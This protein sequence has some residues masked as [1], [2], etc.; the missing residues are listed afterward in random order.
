MEL[1]GVGVGRSVAVGKVVRMPDPLPEPKDARHSGDAAAEK[2]AAASALTFVAA[3]LRARAEKAD[4]EANEVLTATA[5]MAEDPSIL[6]SVNELIDGGKAAERAVFEAFASFREMLISLGGMMAERATD[7][8]DVSQ[9]VVARLR[10]VEAPGVPQ[11]DE[12]FVLVADDLAPADTALLELDKVLA[13]VTRQGGPTSHTAILARS[14]AIPAIMGVAEALD[15]A[16]DTLVIVDAGAGMITTEPTAEQVSAAEARIAELAAAAN[17]PITDGALA[18]GTL[19]PLLANL[20]TPSEAAQAVELGAEGVGLFRTE[21]MFLD[22]TSAPTV[23]EQTKEYTEML[24]HF[25]GKKVVVRALDAGADKPLSFMDMGEEVNPALGQRGLR[26]LRVNE[27]ILRDQLT[28]LVNA[29]NATDADLWVMAPMVSDAEETDY[30]VSL[31]RELGLNTV[32]VMAEVPS[33]AVLA[34]QVAERSDFVS[35][36]SNDLTQYTL[37]ADRML[38]TLAK[39]Q[40]PWH[41]AVLRMVKMLG[42]AGA[43]A[44]KPVGVCGEAAADPQL[45]IVLVGLGVTSLSMT[46]AALADVR[47]ELLTV[48]LEQAKARAAAAINA[49]TGPTAREAAANAA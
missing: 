48:T 21:L 33:L 45:A 30:F 36:G 26:S 49:T 40:D 3:D 27:N 29:Q 34:D 32:G 17:A 10:G 7:L 15:L 9:R 46:P 22:A 4:A 13:L 37:A 5:L 41:P 11:R 35:I 24:Q 18:D 43:A 25:P 28:A 8:S 19:V 20:G 1:Q 38:G 42:D 14:K 16:D 12:P 31:G 47:A 44:G 6:D 2:E 23:E 39:F